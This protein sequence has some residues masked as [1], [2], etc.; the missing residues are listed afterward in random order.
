MGAVRVLVVDDAPEVRHLVRAYLGAGA[1]VVACADVASAK[2]AFATQ[3]FDLALID[4]HLGDECGFALLAALRA[5]P[6]GPATRILAMS[7]ASTTQDRAQ[8]HRAGFD[9]HVA[10]PL[11]RHR[12]QQALAEASGDDATAD[13]TLRDGLATAGLGGSDTWTGARVPAIDDLVPDMLRGI[14]AS[15]RQIGG[16]LAADALD[17][18]RRIGHRIAGSG[19]VYGFPGL[20][21]LGR[22]IETAARAGDT[23]AIALLATTLEADVERALAGPYPGMGHG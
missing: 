15:A 5:L 16:L 8:T 14:A 17:T 1:D 21:A 12:L 3:H 23:R 11:S 19:A 7:A 22:A 13:V 2:D 20:G 6:R 18:I 10:K 4:L 9:G